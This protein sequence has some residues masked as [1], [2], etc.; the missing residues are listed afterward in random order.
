MMRTIQYAIDTDTELVWSRVYGEGV[1]I[2]VI[3]FESG[4]DDND[5][6]MSTPLEKFDEFEV[7][8]MMDGLLTWTK[9]IPKEVKNMHREFWGFKLLK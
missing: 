9:K 2:P 7:L 5:F 8:P 3:D 1:A 4:S 6:E